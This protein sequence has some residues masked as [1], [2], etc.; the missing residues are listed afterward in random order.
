MPGRSDSNKLDSAGSE[1]V[2]GR[3]SL[4]WVAG[5]LWQRLMQRFG[6]F[7]RSA[8]LVLVRRLLGE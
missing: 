3:A 7:Y 4:R 2:A 1:W 5:A 6:D 8:K